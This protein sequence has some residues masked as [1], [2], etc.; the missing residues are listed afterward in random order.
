MDITIAVRLAISAIN[1]TVHK[2]AILPQSNEDLLADVD[3]SGSNVNLSFSPAPR[4][5]AIPTVEDTI[6]IT[7]SVGIIVRSIV[8]PALISSL[9][10]FIPD[11]IV[12]SKGF[13]IEESIPF[14]IKRCSTMEFL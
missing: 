2:A 14:S 9:S 5:A 6:R 3:K 11:L 10:V 7:I 4:S 13:N 12:T 1:E 8:A